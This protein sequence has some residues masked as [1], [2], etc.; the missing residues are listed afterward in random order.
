MER[1]R[2]AE[3]LFEDGL[4]G[5]ELA[6]FC[7]ATRAD[8][9]ELDSIDIDAFHGLF[10]K[11]LLRFIQHT[12]RNVEPRDTNIRKQTLQQRVVKLRGFFQIRNPSLCLPSRVNV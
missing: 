2:Y 3:E 1:E 4:D 11:S 6:I 8:Q 12:P 5:V 10:H 7:R 9:A